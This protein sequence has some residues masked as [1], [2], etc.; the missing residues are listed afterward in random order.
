MFKK[1]TVINQEKFTDSQKLSTDDKF[2]DTFGKFE[3]IIGKETTQDLNAEKAIV[4]NKSKSKKFNIIEEKISQPHTIRVPYLDPGK[5]NFLES[6]YRESHYIVENLFDDGSTLD[7]YIQYNTRKSYFHTSFDQTINYL[8]LYRNYS[9]QQPTTT[10]DETHVKFYY[11]K[12]N[13]EYHKEAMDVNSE[14]VLPN[15]Y[16]DIAIPYSTGE[17]FLERPEE[18]VKISKEQNK[19]NKNLKTKNKIL[20]LPPENFNDNKISFEKCNE[21]INESIK[22]NWFKSHTPVIADEVNAFQE[23][24]YFTK[25]SINRER[26]VTSGEFVVNNLMFFDKNK[27]KNSGNF[28]LS[29]LL[30][31]WH[32]T[33]KAKINKN[34][35]FV[36]TNLFNGLEQRDK[37]NLYSYELIEWLLKYAP[38]IVKDYGPDLSEIG[39][40]TQSSKLS[41]VTQ[42]RLMGLLASIMKLTDAF[43][44]VESMGSDSVKGLFKS[45]YKFLPD[46]RNVFNTGT[47]LVSETIFYRIDKFAEDS[48][49][50]NPI[51][52][53]MI[54]NISSPEILE[55]GDVKMDYKKNPILNY[56]DTQVMYG[57]KYRYSIS[58]VKAIMGFEYE[59][60]KPNN[61]NI[62]ANRERLVVRQYPR[63]RIVEVPVYSQIGR[64][65][66]CPPLPPEF[67]IMPIRRVPNKFR[68]FLKSTYGTRMMRPIPIDSKALQDFDDIQNNEFMKT[69]G[70]GIVKF[71]DT[72]VIKEFRIFSS[73]EKPTAA[74]SNN[75]DLAAREAVDL[76]ANYGLLLGRLYATVPV[77]DGDST[78]VDIVLEP[79]R[80]YYMTFVSVSSYDL[81]SNPT[82]IYEF[83][84]INDAGLS[85]LKV[86]PFVPETDEIYYKDKKKIHRIIEIKP[87]VGQREISYKDLP[88]MLGVG[89]DLDPFN[90]NPLAEMRGNVKNLPVFLG[91][92]ADKLFP[93]SNPDSTGAKSGKKF[94][95]RLSSVKSNKII[96]LNVTFKHERVRSEFDSQPVQEGNIILEKDMNISSKPISNEIVAE[97]QSD[98]HDIR[99]IPVIFKYE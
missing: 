48:N 62:D 24:P 72:S 86:A 66:A 46:V 85:Y 13:E 76:G 25:V 51:Q 98:T 97:K 71:E 61:Q 45:I 32:G 99:P 95:F 20:I 26:S 94:K 52:T 30:M 57:K 84:M 67:E 35:G 41:K 22:T 21:F 82:P 18:Y 1:T 74:S 65:V 29:T 19:L 69:K 12:E 53:I 15:Y 36:M 14:I 33:Q 39:P 60:V 75:Y 78:A 2:F 44:G 92:T 54:P 59:F 81:R 49:D 63:I 8:E 43:S 90:G 87:S 31:R 83:E 73:F 9:T 23:I 17:F 56:I 11:H 58:E 27:F 50:K 16:N 91:T 70:L 64:I 7:N 3:M 34:Y 38:A 10:G 77:L 89:R 93:G 96:D 88:G 79:N 80:K 6:I 5:L 47:P 40:E 68:L 28:D 37:T 42:T 4:F 55:N